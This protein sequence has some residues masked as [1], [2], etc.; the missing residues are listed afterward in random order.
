MDSTLELK[1][2][3]NALEVINPMTIISSIQ[4]SNAASSIP[5]VNR[6]KVF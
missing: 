6:P 2:V 5:I 1:E 4:V 3:S